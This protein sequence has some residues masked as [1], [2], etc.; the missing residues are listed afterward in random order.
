MK[1]RI[2][3]GS[4]NSEVFNKLDEINRKLSDKIGKDF[5]DKKKKHYVDD[6]QEDYLID[7][8]VIKK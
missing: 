7:V 5:Y 3:K 4:T 6:L 1:F 8:K 2:K